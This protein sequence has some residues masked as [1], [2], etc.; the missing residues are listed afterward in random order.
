L[1]QRQ[2]KGGN[3]D[4]ISLEITSSSSSSIRCETSPSVRVNEFSVSNQ[5]GTSPK[6]ASRTTR[7]QCRVVEQTLT[8]DVH[9]TPS[10]PNRR[11]PPPAQISIMKKH[12]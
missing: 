4:N 3:S 8:L 1:K 12:R 10:S 9:P 7:F 11:E 5:V 2:Q 6:S